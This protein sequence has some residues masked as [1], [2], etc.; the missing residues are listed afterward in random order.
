MSIATLSD[1]QLGASLDIRVNSVQVTSVQVAGKPALSGV[2]STHTADVTPAAPT[3]STTTG[4]TALAMEGY[5]TIRLGT[6][7]MFAFALVGTTP[8]NTNE[9]IIVITFPAEYT[10]NFIGTRAATGTVV[11]RQGDGAG[12]FVAGDVYSNTGTR[13]VDVL[14]ADNSLAANTIYRFRG[15]LMFDIV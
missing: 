10:G 3:L 2:V 7:G 14:L 15:T 9:Q 1:A 11:A 12:L 4:M 5:H 8:N 6:V 13:S